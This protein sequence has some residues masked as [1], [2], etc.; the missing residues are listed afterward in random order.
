MKHFYKNKGSTI[1]EAALIY[2]MIIIIAAS[3]LS[4]AIRIELK[5]KDCSEEYASVS[6][7]VIHPYFSAEDFLRLRYYEKE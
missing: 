7:H 3:L 4:F 1:V 6:N 2:P 5:V